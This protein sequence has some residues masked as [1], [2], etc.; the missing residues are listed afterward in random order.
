M[1]NI[2][3]LLKKNFPLGSTN[4]NNKIIQSI[5]SIETYAYVTSKDLLCK[6][7]HLTSQQADIRKSFL[8]AKDPYEAKH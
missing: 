2:V 5:D 3:S 4:N 6:K 7:F 1:K 8:N